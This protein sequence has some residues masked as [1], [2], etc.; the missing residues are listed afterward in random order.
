MYYKKIR[1]LLLTGLMICGVNQLY[2][3]DWL[4][5]GGPTGDFHVKTTELSDKWPEAG[6]KLLWKRTLG[7]GYSTIL[8]KDGKLYTMYSDS[9]KE[10]IISL[11]TKTGKTIWEYSYPRKFWSDMRDWFG[12]GPN[13]SPLI[14]NDRIIA[15]GIAGDVHCLEL[16]SGKLLWKLNITTKFGRLERMEE[17]GYSASPIRY[18]NIVILH[19]GGTEHS[20]IAVNPKDGTIVWKGGPGGVSYAQASVIKLAGQ[21][22]FIYFSPKGVN[23]VD[24]ST[25]KFLWHHKIP[26]SNGNNLTPIVQCDENHIFVQSQFSNGGGRL[27][28][29]SKIKKKMKVEELWFETN[30]RGSCWT[31]FR[32]GDYIYG[33]AGSHTSSKFTA[34]EW[35]TGK[36]VWEHRKFTMAQCLY[37][38]NKAIFVDQ[39]GFLSMAK[40][41]PEKFEVLST[42]K[43]TEQVS[44][45]LPTLVGTK[46][47]LR[48]RENIMAVELGKQ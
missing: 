31:L 42:V 44:W 47:Y 27:L 4:Q 40:I 32:I 2:A 6:P 18:K 16:K 30:L 24:P 3:Q 29:V 41:S 48:D 5:W 37:A 33:S 34:F 38:D 7:E 1:S 20:L 12:V 22:Q 17:Y 8:Q 45:T 23:G 43:M 36:I 19:V 14:F 25:G 11:E 9:L 39:K 28:K 21:D 15:V 10:T 26:I 35:K 13:A 46:L